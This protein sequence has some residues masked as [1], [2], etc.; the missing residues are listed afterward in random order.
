ML[1]RCS[2]CHKSITPE[3]F[4][5]EACVRNANGHVLETLSIFAMIALS[6]RRST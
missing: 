5:H 6:N 3:Q 4:M 1:T 2:T